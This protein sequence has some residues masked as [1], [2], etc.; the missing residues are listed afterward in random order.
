MLDALQVA[1]QYLL[2]PRRPPQPSRDAL[3]A[4]QDRQVR[5]HLAWVRR[6]S[7]FYR[8]L[9]AGLDPRDWRQFPVIEKVDMMRH[10]DRLNTAGV[11]LQDALDVAERAER[12]RDFRPDLHGLTVGLSSGTSGARGVFLVGRAERLRWAG[13]VLRHL[14]PGGLLEPQR[15]AFFLRANSGLYGSVASRRLRFEFFDLMRPLEDQ[16]GRLQALQ[17]SLIVGPPSA[18]RLIAEAGLALTPRLAVSVAEVLEPQDAALIRRRLAPLAQV[19]QATEGL[20]GFSCPHGTLHLNERHVAFQFE[21]AGGGRVQ[22]IISD[23]RRRTQ[24]IVRYRLNDLLLPMEQPCRCGS[25]AF[26][27]ARVEGRS[28]DVL[29]LPGASGPV[30]VFPD[31][32]R[33]ALMRDAGLDEYHARQVGEDTLEVQLRPDTPERRAAAEV[34]LCADLASLGVVQL[35]LRFLPYAFT[36]GPRKLRRVEQAWNGED[37]D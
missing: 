24:P 18:L 13:V 31:F 12:E 26:A 17:P 28:D 36:P 37:Q 34:S 19:Y 9:Y 22:P 27:V 11:R 4:W 20:L 2:E 33:R 29:R 14:L 35:Q 21:D 5:R 8:D 3:L 1:A 25:P 10:F 32:V 6:H 23:F 15:V 16:F 30:R 7:P